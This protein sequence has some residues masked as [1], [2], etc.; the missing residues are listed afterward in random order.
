[1]RTR[2]EIEAEILALNPK[3]EG[4]DSDEQTDDTVL[5]VG[6]HDA[7][8]WALGLAEESI[9]EVLGIEPGESAGSLSDQEGNDAK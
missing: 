2:E 9:S 1:M 8:R 3:C 6:A 4:Y 5:A 7:L